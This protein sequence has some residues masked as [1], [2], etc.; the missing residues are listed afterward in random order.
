M[1][2]MS[3]AP[4]MVPSGL[5]GSA[6]GAAAP[7]PTGGAAAAA[8]PG[9]GIG[10]PD[11]AAMAAAALAAAKAAAMAAGITPPG[12]GSAAGA[13][14]GAGSGPPAAANPAGGLPGGMMQQRA[15]GGGMGGPSPQGVR[16]QAAAQ[17]GAPHMGAP[18]MMPPP[19]AGMPPPMFPPGGC[20]VC[21]WGFG[22]LRRCN[23]LWADCSSVSGCGRTCQAVGIRY[24]VCVIVC[25]QLGQTLKQQSRHCQACLFFA[26]ADH[27]HL[28]Q[29]VPPRLSQGQQRLSASCWRI[30]SYPFCIT[31]L[32]VAFAFVCWHSTMLPF[33]LPLLL[34]HTGMPPGMMP[35]PGMVPPGM[36]PF[37]APHPGMPFGPPGGAMFPPHMAPHMQVRSGASQW[38]QLIG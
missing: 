13:P 29:G 27:L 16:P 14:A 28:V 11:T 4:M 30:S 17:P 21:C 36:P 2:G 19:Y 26:C 23:G 33:L 1:G 9:G 32:P 35:P 37:G 3:R 10:Q 25:W 15:P 20:R 5:S 7:S 38:A 22:S 6:G 12:V 18:G 24:C 31:P 34:L 8:G